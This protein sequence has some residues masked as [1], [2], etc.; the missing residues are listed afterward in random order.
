M[1]VIDTLLVNGSCLYVPGQEEAIS[2]PGSVIQRMQINFSAG[3]LS[4]AGT[5]PPGAEQ[6]L[7]IVKPKVKSLLLCQQDVL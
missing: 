1:I 7:Q 2:N 4:A 5:Y 3:T 6:T